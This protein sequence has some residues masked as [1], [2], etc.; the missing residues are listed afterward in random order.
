[1]PGQVSIDVL[2]ELLDRSC[3]EL[4]WISEATVCNTLR[5]RL[6]EALSKVPSGDRG[7]VTA[8]LRVFVG[9]LDAQRGADKSISDNA[10]WL[11]RV[12]A[13]YLIAHATTA[14][15]REPFPQ[16]AAQELAALKR[17]STNTLAEWLRSHPTDTVERFAP[18]AYQATENWCA[19]ATVELRLPDGSG[20]VRRAYFY[21]PPLG[22]K[23]TLPA[24]ASP[25]VI[26]S[27]CVLGAV[28]ATVEAPTVADAIRL[29]TET[30]DSLVSRYGG[31][32]RP[33]PPGADLPFV[34]GSE[35]KVQ[36]P[37][38]VDSI[39]V[40]ATAETRLLFRH[41]PRAS[42]LG[43]AP[44]SGLSRRPAKT[45]DEQYREDSLFIGEAAAL[46]G[47]ESAKV[48]PL[49]TLLARAESARARLAHPARDT[50][51]AAA[52][53][54]VWHWLE[55]ARPLDA[56]R[57]AA[58]YLAADRLLANDAVS[59]LFAANEDSAPGRRPLE[60]W[61]AGFEH[62]YYNDEFLYTHTWLA[63]ALRLDSTSHAANL[64]FVS[65]IGGCDPGPVIERGERY[66]VKIADPALRA[67][68]HFALGDAYADSVGLAGQVDVGS[69]YRHN[70][71]DA[72]AARAKAIE[73]Y[74]SGLA[75]DHSSRFARAAW[76]KA[77]RLLAGVPPLGLVFHC[78]AD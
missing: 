61:G 30:A 68:L 78:E 74:R 53:S 45:F 2:G 55:H 63:E 39:T 5:D 8:A 57:R 70:V 31:V 58:A 11:L 44:V 20:A 19:R 41:G 60:A 50:L 29:G 51:R 42:A 76:S 17:A 23:A 26:A 24:P 52:V 25:E 27:Q 3:G 62:E 6:K 35:L 37:W 12:N 15:W 34:A 64:A 66:M 77:W 67:Q 16:F 1:V 69:S 75:I 73:H 40:L 7:G 10:Y 56:G 54:T 48:A 36:G 21:P 22:P 71:Q 59:H 38:A 14:V 18:P 13:G 65:L 72:P 49:V 33:W 43:F 32:P 4:A 47:L 46:T 28:W 9:V